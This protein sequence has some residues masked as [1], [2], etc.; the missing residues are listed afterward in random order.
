MIRMVVFRGRLSLGYVCFRE[1]PM[2]CLPWLPR[3]V[4]DQCQ[5][6]DSVNRQVGLSTRIVASVSRQAHLA[7]FEIVKAWR[8]PRFVASWSVFS[9]KRAEVGEGRTSI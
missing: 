6:L 3:G 1:M 7:G 5:G 2:C 8:L 4:R 9:T